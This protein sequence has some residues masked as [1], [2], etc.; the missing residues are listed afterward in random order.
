MVKTRF[1]PYYVSL[2]YDAC[3]KSFW[4]KRALAKFLRQCGVSESFVG[5]WG[6][7]ESKRDF[8]DRVFGALSKSDRGRAGLL[9]L[10]ESLI[11]Q[12]SFPDLENWE[13]S[14][15]KIK[16]A[17][18]AVGR[19]RIYHAQQDEELQSEEAKSKAR[20]AFRKHQNEVTRS[21]RSLQR[22]SEQLNELGQRLGDQRAGYHFQEW[23]YDLLDFSEI[24][25]RRPYVHGGRQI[26]GSVTLSGT[27]YLV[28]LKFTAEQAS[29]TDIDTFF[30]KVTTK[31]DNT[32]GIV[33]S[34]SGYST[35]AKQEA[36]GDRTP[37]LLLDHSHLYLVL[38]GMMGFADVVERV[39]RHA[40][41]TGEAYLPASDF[42]G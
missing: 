21:Q 15:K 1:T 24:Q 25:N 12:R 14:A 33:V 35:V 10:A 38:G 18:D 17:H 26:D 2:I 27:T 34:I 23:F 6:P 3:L 30:K 31:A 40:S 37:I 4:R 5:T 8:L 19:L 13:D 29:A 20:Q 7:E 36:S 39:R 42:G 22:L 28:E 9:R 32:M 41:Q 11:D 16:D